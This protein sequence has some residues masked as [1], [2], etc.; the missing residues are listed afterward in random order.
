MRSMKQGFTLVELL[1]SVAIFAAVTALVLAKYQSFNGGIILTDAAY[2][3]ALT[4]REAQTYGI[5]VQGNATTFN[6]GYGVHFDNTSK[7]SFILFSDGLTCPNDTLDCI[8]DGVYTT[9]PGSPDAN[10]DSFMLGR[11][12]TVEKVCGILRS[13]GTKYCS[14]DA[15]QVPQ[16]GGMD[17]SFNRPDPSARIRLLSSTGNSISNQVD[18]ARITL[19]ASDGV[20]RRDVVVDHT[21]QISIQ[22]GQ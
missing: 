8:G 4:V 7:N 20:S 10:I 5:N 18:E 17:I 22:N 13:S 21:G 1:V 12:I 2:E 11:G 3:V 16:V 14:N 19:I 15:T 6:L 9:Y